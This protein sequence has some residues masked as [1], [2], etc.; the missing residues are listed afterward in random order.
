MLALEKRGMMQ[1]DNMVFVRCAEVSDIEFISLLE[2]KTFSEPWSKDNIEYAIND[3]D[4]V[5]LVAEIDGEK[6]GYISG[7]NIAGEMY[8]NNVA[9]EKKYRGKGIGKRLVAQ[10]CRIAK[11]SKCILVTLEVRESNSVAIDLYK[12]N[13]FVQVGLRKNFYSSPTENALI[14]TK[15]IEQTG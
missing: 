12:Q 1:K 6:V 8:F 11:Q 3:E 14:L 9:V 13:G 10:I 4:T 7:K 15:N 5:F 2:Q